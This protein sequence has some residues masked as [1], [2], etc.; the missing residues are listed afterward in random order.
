L[1]YP[2]TCTHSYALTYAHGI[3]THCHDPQQARAL[4]SSCGCWF[5]WATR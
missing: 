2:Q 4:A 1:R 5:G 3:Q